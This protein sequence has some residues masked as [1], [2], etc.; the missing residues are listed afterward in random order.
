MSENE[1]KNESY[2]DKKK[3][4]KQREEAAEEAA[5]GKRK[6]PQ[7]LAAERAVLSGITYSGLLRSMAFEQVEA[8]WF[9]LPQHKLIFEAIYELWMAGK[10]I[11]GLVIKD[12]M[13]QKGTLIDAGGPEYLDEVLTSETSGVHLPQYIEM[14]SE[15][16]IGRGLHYTS[17]EILADL[18]VGGRKASE[19]LEFASDRCLQISQ[20][21][22]K[23]EGKTTDQL[24]N[25]IS[26]K[27]DDAKGDPTKKPFS[28]TTGIPYLDH[29]LNG[30]FHNGEMIVVAA[31][32]SVGK[33]TTLIN[34]NCSRITEAHRHEEKYTP[35]Y[36]TL[37]MTQ[38]QISEAHLANLSITNAN[39]IQNKNFVDPN[40]GKFK[41]EEF[42]RVQRTIPTYKDKMGIIE[43]APGVNT[44]QIRAK[45]KQ[46]KSIY[47]IDIAFID[48]LTLIR[49]MNPNSKRNTSEI[50]G[51]ISRATKQTALELEIPIVI[52]AQ[53]NRNVEDRSSNEPY[54]S[55]IRSSD[56]IAQDADVVLMPYED[57]SEDGSIR[58]KVA[59]NRFGPTT[60]GNRC[61]RVTFNRECRR[62][63][64]FD[65]YRSPKEGEVE[66]AWAKTKV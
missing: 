29:L 31:R 24:F 6:P 47:N 37:E 65:K 64:E 33:T 20:A 3:R 25:E 50:I 30:G 7:D 34:F 23:S 12:K 15:M 39:L 53:L 4:K 57:D 54:L 17:Q 62:F 45:L 38:E 56:A 36:L 63:E 44:M 5:I 13:H 22:T 9:Y 43:M 11:D 1:Y 46:L 28:I 8:T 14:L 66:D 41:E 59:K 19:V 61:P 35:Y 26:Q 2:S 48:Y 27:M 10:Q 21:T 49:P 51:D 52:A 55:D 40:T 18:H 32:T 60:K 16:R 42:D 58:I